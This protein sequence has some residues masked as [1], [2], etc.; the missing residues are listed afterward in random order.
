MKYRSNTLILAVA[1]L[2]LALAACGGNST[3]ADDPDSGLNNNN[4]STA[5]CGN[6]IIEAG[7]D[8]DATALGGLD[9]EDV[10]LGTG[11][12]TCTT[13]CS[14]DV[15]GCT[16]QPQCGNGD[17]EYGETCDSSDLGGATCA[18]QG[19]A[20][21][22]L[23]CDA[24]CD[25]DVSGCDSCGN[26]V[27]DAGEQCDGSDLGGETCASQSLGTGDLACAADCTYDVSDCTEQPVCGDDTAEGPEA[28]D[29]VDL[30][31]E[32]CASLGLGTG[33]LACDANCGFD[34]SDCS[35]PVCGDGNL[36][37]GE[38]CDGGDLGGNDCTDL[39]FV[40]GTLACTGACNFDDSGCSDCETPDNSDP[41]A[42]NHVPAPETLGAPETTPISADLFD[43]CGIDTS[44]VT[45]R[46]IITPK[47]GPAQVLSVTPAVTGTGT[48]VTATY[49]HPGGF[50]AGTI[51][52][53]M[54]SAND[55][56]GNT[57]VENWRFSVVDSMQLFSGGSGGMP[58]ANPIDESQPNTNLA[59]FAE[60]HLIGGG[61]GS[62]V[63]Y[64]IRFSP[65]VPVGAVIF[66][67]DLSAG[68]CP[69]GVS[70]GATL[71]CYQLNADS[72][73]TQSTWNNRTTSVAWSTP[74]ADATPADRSATMTGSIPF[75]TATP[76]YTW[77]S[78]NVTSLVANWAAGDD[79]FGIVCI[80][81]SPTQLLPICS[82][83]SNAPPK[84]DLTFGPP[85]P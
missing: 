62:E 12:L 33:N 6:G 66:S 41:T 25:L 71:D 83:F 49:N 77:V 73:A 10:N 65:A 17:L 57:L 79:Y 21:G 20:S 13:T 82:P 85:L 34:T 2:G 45:M 11:E 80:N 31:G 27:L 54:L 28:C 4:N 37:P 74:G 23:A 30:R 18:S 29:G 81:T 24:N 50:T 78:D 84:I 1:G 22:D 53:V 5:E 47:N 75:N 39:G 51:V 19:Y 8:C 68:I 60:S 70:G 48:N 40:G 32:D 76:L 35:V 64:L 58:M 36:D 56:N 67:A 26:D 43:S 3:V 7:E 15:S 16:E 69:P 72:L 44:S 9:C 42:S 52:E 63:R 14:Y 38:Q 61:A 55:V 59:T 46:L